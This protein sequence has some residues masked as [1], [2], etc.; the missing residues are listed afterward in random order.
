CHV[1]LPAMSQD[2]SSTFV[3]PDELLRQIE[4]L[5]HAART[6]RMVELG[7]HA[8]TDPAVAATLDA[9]EGGDWYARRLALQ[10][11]FGS[12]DGA[13]VVRAIGDPS[14]IVRGLAVALAPLTCDDRQAETA[15]LAA[16]RAVRRALLRRLVHRGRRGPIDAL[17]DRLAARG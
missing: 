8:A 7:R 1:R 11:C 9:L 4:P 13:R 15:V 2:A 6:R 3:S 14:R 10:S 12:R 5:S 16:P 17:L